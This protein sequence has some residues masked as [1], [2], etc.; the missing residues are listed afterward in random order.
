VGERIIIKIQSG[1]RV[2]M[3]GT[4]YGKDAISL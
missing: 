2:H 1:G 3:V 4:V